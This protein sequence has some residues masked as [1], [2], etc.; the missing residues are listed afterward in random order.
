MQDEAGRGGQPPR[1]SLSPAGPAGGRGPVWSIL[2]R[3]G[4]G[5]SGSGS[6]HRPRSAGRGAP[7]AGVWESCCGNPSQTHRSSSLGSYGTTWLLSSCPGPPPPPSPSSKSADLSSLCHLLCD[8]SLGPSSA[9]SGCQDPV[10][11]PLLAPV[12][13]PLSGRSQIVSQ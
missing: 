1:T 3:A 12:L 8:P 9:Q 5:E 2:Q 13:P 4:P 6:L 10:L 11:Q 7:W